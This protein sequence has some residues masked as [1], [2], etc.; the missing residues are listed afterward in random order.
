MTEKQNKDIDMVHSIMK[1]AVRLLMNLSNMEREKISEGKMCCH[2]PSPQML[3]SF[4][5]Y[6]LIVDKEST[7]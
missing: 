2:Q 1:N 7:R 3:S 5:D 4:I 6:L